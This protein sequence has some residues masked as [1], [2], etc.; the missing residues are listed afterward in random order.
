MKKIH[1]TL[2][3]TILS[4]LASCVYTPQE[5]KSQKIY[6][7]QEEGEQ[8]FYDI[9][10]K[11]YGDIFLGMPKEVVES[12]LNNEVIRNIEYTMIPEYSEN[13]KLNSL[14]LKSQNID[15]ENRQNVVNE[16]A[17]IF[18]PKYGPPVYDKISNDKNLGITDIGYVNGCKIHW[19]AYWK[20]ESKYIVLG[21]QD[22]YETITTTKDSV[23]FTNKNKYINSNIWIWIFNSTVWKNQGGAKSQKEFLNF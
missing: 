17:T 14:Y 21:A 15:S 5:H 8:I 1:S 13:L 23:E 4:L 20:F 18:N 12:K 7:T 16:L 19:G 6:S 3:I 9:T 11:A 22:N 10:Q 2:L